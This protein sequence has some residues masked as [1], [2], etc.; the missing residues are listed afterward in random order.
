[1]AAARRSTVV[2]AVAAVSAFGRGA[3]AL[4]SAALAGRPA[5][6]PVDRFD[7]SRRRVGVAA[8]LPGAP[9][10]ADELAG[11]VSDACA[12]AGLDASQR[13]GSGLFLAV[14]GDPALAR[15]AEEDRPARSASTVTTSSSS[16]EASNAWPCTD[17]VELTGTRPACRPSARCSAAA[18][19][20]SLCRVPEP[21]ALT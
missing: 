20:A 1:M 16:P 8:T 11:V 4:L 2:T 5:F 10:L 19:A 14:H 15:A 13:A 17:F 7:V 12:A 21:W 6:R 18:S 3:D 9:V